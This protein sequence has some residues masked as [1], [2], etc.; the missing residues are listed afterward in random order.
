[1]I[2]VSP[3]SDLFASYTSN[4]RMARIH[5][6]KNIYLVS[7][8]LVFSGFCKSTLAVRKEDK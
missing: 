6:F 7:G 1:M 3:R 4:A 8:F 2:I 5:Y